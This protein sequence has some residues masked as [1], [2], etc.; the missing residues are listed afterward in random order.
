MTLLWGDAADETTHDNLRNCLWNLR[1]ALS[2]TERRVVA[3]EGEDIML[4]IAPFDIDGLAFRRLAAQLGRSELEAAAALYT[5]EFLDGLAIESEEFESWRR[6][7]AVGYRDQVIDV[8]TRLTTQLAAC[9]DRAR[10]R[11]RLADFAA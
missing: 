7:E 11:D 4:D 2:D 9:G 5:G 8:L 1:K 6:A 10:D 3:S